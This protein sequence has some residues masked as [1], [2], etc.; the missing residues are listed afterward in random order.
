MTNLKKIGLTALAGSLVATTAFAGALSVSGGAKMSYV[1]DTGNEDAEADGNRFGLQKAVSMSGSGE[2]DNGHTVSLTHTFAT[3]S[4]LLSSTILSYDMGDMGKLKYHE[5]SA[6]MGIEIIDDLMPTADEEIWNGLD[7]EGS[8]ETPNGRVSHG[9]TGFNY[10]YSAMDGIQVDVGYA[11]KTV[12]T[13]NDDGS[14]SG[15]GGKRSSSSIAVQYT[16]IEGAKLFIGTG[17]AGGATSDTDLDTYGFTYAM[18]SITVG[19]QHTEIDSST[20]NSDLEKDAMGISF[21]INDNL[22]VS[23]GASETEKEGDTDT[24]EMSGFS[25]GYSMGGIT[26]KAHSN[27]GENIQQEAN[28]E[29]EHTEIAVSFA[30]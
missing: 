16:G 20:A 6:A 5:E 24:Q 13:S 25:V 7:T 28:N 27:K 2:L 15:T 18:G 22:S 4:G 9:N 3:E 10:T 17:T 12:S 26:I 1:A 23:Y 21:A 14:T 8:N 19:V 30:F 29:S 11:P